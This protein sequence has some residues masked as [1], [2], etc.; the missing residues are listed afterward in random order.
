MFIV[1]SFLTESLF[2]VEKYESTDGQCI[3]IKTNQNIC[4]RR[5]CFQR[6]GK[7]MFFK[8]Y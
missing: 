2:Y 5:V 4:S 3:K 8:E 7:E 1:M 6:D